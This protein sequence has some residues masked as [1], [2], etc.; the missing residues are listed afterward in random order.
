M[1]VTGQT[2]QG[3]AET[4]ASSAS[5]PINTSIE[6]LF[7]V[8]GFLV[9]YITGYFLGLPNGESILRRTL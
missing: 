3:R 6:L 4:P 7:I 9:A 8:L 1:A 5:K 2:R